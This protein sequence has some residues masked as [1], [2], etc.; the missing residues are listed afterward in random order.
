MLSVIDSLEIVM[1]RGL[2]QT[3][4]MSIAWLAGRS[5]TKVCEQHRFADRASD[6]CPVTNYYS[7]SK[8]LL[9]L[10]AWCSSLS[11]YPKSELCNPG[12]G[13]G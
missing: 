2:R 5:F 12:R 8:H 1:L 4:A 11:L 9:L 3:L 6:R 13:R 7:E 10:V